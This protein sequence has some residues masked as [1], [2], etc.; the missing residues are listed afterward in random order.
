ME[1]R[2]LFAIFLSFLVLYVYQ[3]LIVK[4]VPKRPASAVAANTEQQAATPAVPSPSP[5]AESLRSE[6]QRSSAAP[7]VSEGA[8]RDLPIET[9]NVVAVFTNR[10]AR[11]K[12]WKLKHYK[13]ATGQPQELIESGL[14]VATP[15]GAV[16]RQPLPFS[17]KAPDTALSATLNG[18][19][20]AVTQ[21]AAAPQ[22]LRFEYRDSAGLHVTKQFHVD[23]ASYVVTFQTSVTQ[24][25]RPVPAAI[26]WGPGLADTA[27]VSRYAQQPAGLLFRNGKVQR[28]S[29]KDIAK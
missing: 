19:L 1:R 11:L 15:G 23:P 7:L 12:S 28:L 17:L 10:G 3:A 16:E 26:L 4:P 9:R 18:S 6:P 2:V 29:P 24:G 20:Y 13:D 14:T 8:E 5:A 25:D 27:E 21:S 22:D